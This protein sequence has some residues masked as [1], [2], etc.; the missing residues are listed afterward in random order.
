M[1]DRIISVGIDVGT[2]TTQ[3]IFSRLTLEKTGGFGVAPKI[4]VA[5]RE[6]IYKSGIYFTPLTASG[7]IDGEKVADILTGEY[8]K[9]G[10]KPGML[11]SGAVIIT[12][13]SAKK[14]NAKEVIQAIAG[15]AGDFVV[16]AAGPDFESLLA[17]KGSGAAAASER[18]KKNILN[19]D[20]GGG[21]TNLCLFSDGKEIDSGCYD[22]GGRAVCC[23]GRHV[24]VSI[25]P[26]V[27]AL[28][29]KRGIKAAV[30]D[31]LTEKLGAQIGEELAEILLEAANLKERTEDAALF[32]TNHGLRTEIPAAEFWFS[33]GVADCIWQEKEDPYR[34]GDIGVFLGRALR[35]NRNWEK[36]KRVVGS[37]TVR[38]T[39]IG[40][41]SCSLEV[42]GSTIYAR[43]A[44]LPVKNLPVQKLACV[45]DAEIASMDK[46]L[47]DLKMQQTESFEKGYAIALAG[48]GSPSFAQLEAMADALSRVICREKSMIPIIIE[49]DFAKALGQG[50]KRR[51]PADSQKAVLCLDQ[52]VCDRGDFIDI[53]EPLGGGIALPVIVKTL[54]FQEESEK[55]LQGHERTGKEV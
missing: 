13:E 39:V 8:R 43:N 11:K 41:G 52:I 14:R 31:V 25:S 22:I 16:A 27:E 17:G 21:T 37:E 24:I 7:D 1:E 29:K 44:K 40:A 6:V 42:S 33:G 45:T 10:M 30:G 55:Y 35:K 38:A 54:I 28:L 34:Y 19:L 18:G 23:D 32:E 51:L 4:Q 26:K 36:Q 9:A 48:P 49:N 12:G 47:A 20:I 15:L 50:I 46:Q 3:L 5:A 53:G 2:S